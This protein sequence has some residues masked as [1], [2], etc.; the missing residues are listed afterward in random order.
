[1]Y[2]LAAAL[3][4]NLAVLHARRGIFADAAVNAARGVHEDPSLTQL[5]KNAGDY[6]YRAGRYDEA[7]DAYQRAVKLNPSLGEDVY[8]KL[9]NIRYRRGEPAEAERCWDRALSLDPEN[10][11]IRANLDAV[12]RAQVAARRS[13]S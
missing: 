12:R 13:Q 4:N 8:F 10:S 5:H 3:Y 11:I 2:P 7:L 9:G 1:V 6:A